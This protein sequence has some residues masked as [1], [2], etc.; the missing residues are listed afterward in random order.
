M[1]KRKR[2]SSAS[3]RAPPAKRL[4]SPVKKANK[5]NNRNV[6]TIETYPLPSKMRTK[7]RVMIA[8][9]LIS[10]LTSSA[11]LVYRPTSYFDVDPAVGGESFAGYTFYSGAYG[12]YRVTGFKYKCT[13]INLEATGAIVGCHAIAKSS[14][15][16]SGTATNFTDIAAENDWGKIAVCAP[17]TSSPEKV[18]S[19]YVDCQ[20]LWGT[21][22]VKTDNDW[23][24]GTGTSPT[25]NS[26]LRICAHMANNA[27]M[28]IGVQFIL[29]IESYG[30]W[31][32][33][34]TDITS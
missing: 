30:Y 4:R 21:P 11:A 16:A 23:A 7:L 22:E 10:A 15:P 2:T 28:T 14:T 29:E 34:V 6:T 1:Q 33:K 26:W 13:F 20:K 12:R 5:A 24:G 8:Q 31:D 19:G 17:T 3:T 9:G 27:A 32:E 25:V 18:L